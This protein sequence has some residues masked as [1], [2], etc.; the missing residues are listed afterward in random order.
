MREFN[1]SGPCDPALHYT[2]LREALMQKGLEKVRKGRYFTIFAP[3][4]TGK[5]TYFKLLM[6]ELDRCG[7]LPL[8]VSLENLKTASK[9][10]FYRQLGKRLS[11]AFR[12][13]R[14]SCEASMTNPFDLEDVL[15]NIRRSS[16]PIV[17]IIDEFEGIPDS[18]V[19]EVMHT[20]RYI[21]HQTGNRVIHSLIL[22]G[23]ST[24][25]ELVVSHASPFN[26]ADE[27]E[28][29]YFTFGEVRELIGQY[30]AE[31][32]QVF[33]GD[34]IQAVYENTKGQP[35]LV[36][37]FCQDLVERVAA[38]RACP[39]V[40]DHY[41]TT[42]QYFLTERFDKNIVNIVQKARSKKPFMLN[43]LFGDTPVPFSIHDPDIAWLYANGVLYKDNGNTDILVPL[44]KK[45]LI[46]AFRP[47]IN[48]ETRHY[49]ATREDMR[50]R[51]VSP[52]GVLDLDA[53]LDE[54][55]RYIRRRGFRA[56]DTENLRE[57]AWHYSL[58]GF[59]S[60]F[61]QRLGGETFVE[62]P[63]GRGRTDILI[64]H[65]KKTYIIETK[66][67]TDHTFFQKGKS[68]LARYLISENLSMGH[69]VVFSRLHTDR[70]ILFTSE[71]IEGKH[72]HTHI[73]PVE[74]EVSSRA[75]VPDEL[76]LSR[77][78]IIAANLIK[79]GALSLEQIAESTGVSLARVGELEAMFRVF[80][81]GAM[82]EI[83][84]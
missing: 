75:K 78:E 47:L 18:V 52:E 32:G 23:V 46:I 19:S 82:E 12:E 7:F 15:H 44:Y 42:Q 61:I 65:R 36:C 22:V 80:V 58:D 66:I 76:K 2:V 37:G 21:Y 10:Q 64:R 17:L 25:A 43:L 74:F 50:D 60:F 45:A 53:L 71:V 73:I 41:Y 62:V 39:V 83:S 1:T 69:Y 13:R 40:M 70:Q 49:V 31:S 72:I 9:D 28:V 54:Y 35:G 77:E 38:D 63:S 57:A 79:T 59:I 29:P 11:A 24:L 6:I 5:T 68:Q 4:Q 16:P 81:K 56:F 8:W 20:F 3:R 55:R 48:G 33:E 30:V 34:V 26:V 14:V 67:Y 51:Y 27:L 84:C